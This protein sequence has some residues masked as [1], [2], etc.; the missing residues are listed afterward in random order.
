MTPLRHTDSKLL[1]ANYTSSFRGPYLS[2]A[3]SPTYELTKE[4]FY[5]QF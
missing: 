3:R 5:E 1:R 2:E 4:R